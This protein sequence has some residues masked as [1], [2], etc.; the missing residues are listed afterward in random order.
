VKTKAAQEATFSRFGGLWIDRRDWPTQLKQKVAEG[1]VTPALA[2]QLRRFGRDGFV[3]FPRAVP[4]T[5]TAKLRAELDAFWR[6]PPDEARIETWDNGRLEMLKP[7]LRHRAGVTKLLNYHAFSAA[8]REAIAPPPSRSFSPR[9][10]S[11]SRRRS[12]H[13]CSGKAP[14]RPSTRT[15]PMSRSKPRQWNWPPPGSRWKT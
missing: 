8:A 15:P 9:F 12:S 10:S 5:L 14:S 4:R 13:W 2:T 11:A 7:A 6:N 1:A 3:V